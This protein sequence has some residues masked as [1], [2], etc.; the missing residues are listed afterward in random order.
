MVNALQTIRD[1]VVK[2]EAAGPGERRV[3]SYGGLVLIQK[4]ARALRLGSDARR[5]LAARRDPSQGYETSLV[6]QLLMHGLLRGGEGFSATEPLR[7]DGPLLRMLGVER[8]PSAETVEQVVKYLADDEERRRGP[9][10][11]LR[12]QAGRCVSASSRSDLYSCEGFVPFWG[13]GTLLE[14]VGKD[15]DS[16]KTIDGKRG[17]LASGCFVGPW[18]TGLDFAPQGA[19]EETVCRRL[20]DDTVR[21]VLRPQR[22]MNDVLIL[23]DS[24]YGDGPTLDQLEGYEEKPSY[25]VGVQGLKEARRLMTEA[26]EIQWTDTGA[27]RSR[28][29][30][31]SGV[32][33]MWLQ[34]EG[35]A[36][37]RLMICR[38]WKAEGEFLWNYAAVVTNLTAADKRVTELMKR[39]GCGFEEAIW[40]LYGYKS[41][42]E[43][44][45]KELLSDLGL[46][47]P[48]CAKA[49]VNAV[50]YALAG[51]AYNLAVA[52]RRLGLDGERR[53]MRL[54]RL[55]TEILALAGYVV[56]HGR[57]VVMRLVDA[58]DHLIEQLLAAMGRLARL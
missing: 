23:L 50:F 30:A 27:K 55:R 34:C 40:L 10:R 3:S 8:A 9:D 47:H 44:Q 13:D 31:E 48:P 17:Q 58:R 39:R 19:G 54:W 2:A 53:T 21:E 20:M 26:A 5:L 51:L 14:V 36:S 52:A 29:W 4:L 7:G 35:W 42:M 18:L 32:A 45:W 6:A 49:A 22:L 11:L 24:L 57:T 56:H 33:Q 25:I 37:K 16:I 15:F 12:T 46:H 1:R 38:R 28:G 41:G 43:N